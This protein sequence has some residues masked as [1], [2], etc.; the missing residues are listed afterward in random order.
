MI[1]KVQTDDARIGR[2]SVD[3]L[4]ATCAEQ[5]DCGAIG[6]LGIV[7]AR[8][9]RGV[10]YIAPLH[11]D[12][13]GIGGGDMAVARDVLIE[14]DVHKAVFFQLMH[15]AR[16]GLARLQEPQWFRDWHLIHKDL[17]LG[18]RGLGDAVAGL[19][20]CSLGRSLGHRHGGGA[21]KELADRHRIRRVIRALVDDLQ[22]IIRRQ[23]GRRHLHPA[24]A[25]AVRHRHFA[26]GKG[27]LI[28]RH[29]DAFQDRA[30][31]HAFGLFVQIGK[32]IILSG[33]SAASFWAIAS[34]RRRRISSNS[35]WKST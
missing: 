18:Q 3:A 17:A 2:Q 10:H 6:K 30:A 31:D 4:F 11:L 12:W 20:D 14:L 23:T 22:R 1:F 28:A 5:L 26:A 32:V 16:L 29:S 13:I 15:L 8:N 19:D 35:D 24:R 21:L 27:H 25:P 9:G 7:K 34:A 33:H